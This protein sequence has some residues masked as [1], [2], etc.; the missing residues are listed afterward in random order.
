[1]KKKDALFDLVQ[2]LSKNEKRYFK[3]FAMRHGAKE[4]KNYLKLFDAVETMK[5]YDET[6]LLKK[7]KNEPF[8]KHISGQKNQLYN[9]ILESL[10]IYHNDSSIDREI[11]KYIDLAQILSE[12]ELDE[13]SIKI[14]EKAKKLAYKH[15]RFEVIFPLLKLQKKKGFDRDNLS[16]KEMNDYYKEL[17]VALEKLRSKLEYNHIR[18]KIHMKRRT[19]GYVK[20]PEQMEFMKS[21]YKDPLFRDNSRAGSFEANVYYLL[22]KVEYYRILREYESTNKYSNK[23]F[24]LFQSNKDRIL[25]CT[26]LYINGINC[27]VESNHY[28]NRKKE[29]TMALESLREI[30]SIIGERYTTREIHVKIFETF[31]IGITD[32]SLHFREYKKGLL[33]VADI[34]EGFKKYDDGITPSSK[35]V[36]MNNVACLYFGAEEYRTSLKWCYQIL[37]APPTNN[38]EDIICILK[39][40]NLLIHFELGNQL[41]YPSILRST[42]RFFYKKK[43]VYIFE[44][45]FLKY[46]KLFLNTDSKSELRLLFIKFKE[47]LLPL[48]ENRFE[49]A[50]FN[51]I[52]LIGWIDKKTGVKQKEIK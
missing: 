17:F 39:I 6:L 3:I 12:K 31:Y 40:L 13:Q 42:Y 15:D 22:A 14:I 2:S 9:L 47:E 24:L 35:M 50:I 44:S 41:V 33:H 19:T 52:D 48:I 20:N 38:R 28:L 8:I 34:E 45:L 4:K 10:S 16:E 1:M 18:D 7:L 11:N 51:D 23:L 32:S 36:I 49:G 27:L 37:N 26:F 5:H 43:R 25:D 46:I 29:I 21:F 30:P